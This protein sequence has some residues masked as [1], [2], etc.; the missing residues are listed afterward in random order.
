[1][2]DDRSKVSAGVKFKDADLLGAP[3]RI[4]IGR[5]AADGVVEFSLR[6]RP[7][8]KELAVAELAGFT[9]GLGGGADPFQEAQ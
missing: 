7:E 4:V 3:Y 9:A 6:G 1:M 8:R 5:K 2:L